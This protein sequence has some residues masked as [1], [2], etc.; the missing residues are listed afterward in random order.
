MNRS[1]SKLRH[2]QET[3]MLLENR[4]TKRVI[5][6]NTGDQELLDNACTTWSR[7][8]PEN[9]RKAKEWTKTI[10]GTKSPFDMDVACNSKAEVS[11]GSDADR[12]ILD[13]IINLNWMD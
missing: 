7:Y 1:Y 11:I 8:T 9:K 3:N 13:G 4:L 6:E 5:K 12:K 10:V 2:I